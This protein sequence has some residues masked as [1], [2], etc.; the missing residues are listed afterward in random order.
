M[1]WLPSRNK[2]FTY[3]LIPT[4]PASPQG[5]QGQG[6]GQPLRGGTKS[7]GPAGHRLQQVPGADPG[8]YAEHAA[9]HG[10]P[11]P[12]D[13]GLHC[14]CRPQDERRGMG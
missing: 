1:T 2:A 8:H 13:D 9:H 7:L 5:R 4:S 11:A 3:L 6:Q 12:G 14:W 10:S